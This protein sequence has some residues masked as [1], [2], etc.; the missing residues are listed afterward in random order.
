M[1]G[2]DISVRE[3]NMRMDWEHFNNSNFCLLDSASA[4]SPK[5]NEVNADPYEAKLN[6]LLETQVSIRKDVDKA[7]VKNGLN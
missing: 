4:S 6:E 5:F 2:L 7:L 1:V 3:W